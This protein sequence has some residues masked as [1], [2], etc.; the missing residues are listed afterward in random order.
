MD[1]INDDDDD[2]ESGVMITRN[3]RFALMRDLEREHDNNEFNNYA[4]TKSVSQELLNTTSIQQLI[5]LL[6]SLLS[7]MEKPYDG[8]MITTIVLIT[9][10]LSLQ[11]IIFI[12]IVLIYQDNSLETAKPKNSLVKMLSTV[13]LLT[14]IPITVLAVKIKI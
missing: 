1:T 8:F 14:N 13:V 11:I 5:G 12:L 7:L 3:N 10:S 2:M 4:S 6:I 9:V